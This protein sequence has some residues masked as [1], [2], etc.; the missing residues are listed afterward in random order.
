M[1]V[2]RDV[3]KL[4]A[5]ERG[6][7]LV[8]AAIW[9]PML[10]LFGTFVIDVGNWFV[11]KRHLQM[12]ADAAV[13]AGAQEF[14][15]PGC[16]NSAIQA[17]VAAYG[18]DTYNAQVGGTPSS[19]VF[20]LVNSKTYHGQ[21][22]STA[23]DVTPDD[24]VA[25]DPCE[26]AM[27]DVKMTEVGLPWFLK[28]AGGLLKSVVP[29]VAF[30]NA[31]SRVSV[32]QLDDSVGGLP[33]GVPDPTPKSAR[34]FFVNESTGAVLGSTPLTVVGTSNGIKT[35]DNGSSP[36]A[37]KFNTGDDDVG[38]VI[39]LSGTSS[40]TCGTSLVNCYDAGATLINGTPSKG[41]VHLRGWS[42][43]GS[44][45]QP[46]NPIARQ[47]ELVNGSCS[48][49]Y[50]SSAAASCTIGVRAV[51]DFGTG[52]NDPVPVT[53]GVGAKLTATVNGTTYPLTYATGQWKTAT[54]IPVAPGAGP[55]N[56]TLD[57]EV[58]KG[59]VGSNTCSTAGGNKCKGSFNTVQR[60]FSAV[61]TRSG[62]IKVAQV[63]E[64]GLPVG[65]S[66]EKC[67]AVQASCTHNLV[68]QIGVTNVLSN[69]TSVTDPEVTLRVAGSGSQTQS[70]DCDPN[71]NSNL[72]DQLALGCQ[73]TY[74]RN[75]GQACPNT[76]KGV[77]QPWTCVDIRT[78]QAVNQVGAGMNQRIL[79]TDKPTT[80]TSPNH[81]SDYPNLS[82][83]DPRIV[84]VFLTPFGTF[85][86][87]GS[88]TVPVQDFGTFYVTGWSGS[89]NG[90]NNPCPD[91][92]PASGFITGHFIKFVKSI[93]SG[94]G[95]QPCDLT[96]FGACVAVMTR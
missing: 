86:G 45:V 40:T 60:T 91:P 73:P 7:V 89:G 1:R 41:I 85:Q 24:T 51:V 21:T 49:P 75:T 39:A 53:T 62:P 66:F 28:P 33:I 77:A 38:V 32:N 61:D 56:V 79:G 55:V 23:P 26:A 72:K 20:R 47:V 6:A 4:L 68:V 13:L 78:G 65:G 87:S 67:S 96:S 2:A 18:G 34:A 59:T 12:Q 58:Q 43:A 25:K 8:M 31:H 82:Q 54:T 76:M 19:S 57:W 63:L 5:P 30:I 22:T 81:W 16:S 74:E 71:A 35:F 3:R 70:L 10:L 44:A 37:V 93:G 50:F 84:S 14:R 15:F 27:V 46:S 36:L 48:D 92:V 11:H 29:Q 80:C 52:A 64:N 88:G 83:S 42:A 17:R 69:A 95:T 94:S 90:F 9:L